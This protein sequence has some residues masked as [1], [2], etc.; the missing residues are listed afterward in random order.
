MGESLQIFI[1]N[2]FTIGIIIGIA[3][4]LEAGV[5]I[6]TLFTIGVVFLTIAV[7]ALAW[8]I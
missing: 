6:R 5:L 1:V 8:I 3:K 7:I 2:G 4:E